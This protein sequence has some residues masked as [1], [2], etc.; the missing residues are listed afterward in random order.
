MKKYIFIVMILL[1][2]GL[3]ISGCGKIMNV[4][5]PTMKSE[6]VKGV[7]ICGEKTAIGEVGNS[8]G[9]Q[10]NSGAIKSARRN[11][12]NATGEYDHIFYSPGFFK[13]F[14]DASEQP[15][16]GYVVLDF[17]EEVGTCITVIEQ[18]PKLADNYPEEKANVY[19][20]SNPT[21][22]WELL[23]EA[24][25]QT[26]ELGTSAPDW[27][28]HPNVFYFEGCIQ[29]VKIVDTTDPANFASGSTADGF[30]VD[31]VYAGECITTIEVPVDIKPT[32]CPNPLNTKSKGVL[33]VAILGTEDFD[34][35]VIDPA[36]VLLEGASPLRW[37]LEDVATP[38]EPYVEKKDCYD[39]CNEFGPDGYIDLTL[40][41]KKQ[42]I[43]D[44]LGEVED[45][46]C[47][48]LT[49]QG[50]LFDGTPI[51]GEDVVKILKKGK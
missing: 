30:D 25:N 44:A 36:T 6:I 39:D 9:V 24:T 23:G 47:L 17:G 33:P 26:P 46:D 40:K 43:I 21:G 35:S 2:L 34:V 28:S 16:R 41:F 50:E 42:E 27:K 3:I 8:Q 29:Y 5:V 20:S 22:P 15:I 11:P 38:Y 32:S 13:P 7:T 31:A 10:L 1:G 49:L 37:T 48:V 45:G 18:S 19:V 51:F 4:S 12:L 14:G